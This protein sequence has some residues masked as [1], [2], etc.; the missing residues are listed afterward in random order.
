MQIRKATWEDLSNIFDLSNDI[1]VRD[2]SYTKQKIT[3][4]DH[5]T[6]F[7]NK[8]EDVNYLFLVGYIDNQFFG[9][10][11]F[12]IKD[13]EALIS[14]SVNKNFRG[15]GLAIKFILE[16]IKIFQKQFQDCKIIIAYVKEA[17]T[18]SQKFFEKAGFKLLKKCDIN[19]IDS[20][21]YILHFREYN[22]GN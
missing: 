14:I 4:E 5:Q 10:A 9:Q 21:K 6:W 17:N 13:E 11:R 19:G 8:L 15:K 7:A 18:A 12:E 3:F 2:S 16:A 1:E 22:N 20:R